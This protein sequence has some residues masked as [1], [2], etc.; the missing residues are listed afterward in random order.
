VTEEKWS[1]P[2]PHDADQRPETDQ[3]LCGD[4]QYALHSAL[5]DLPTLYARLWLALQPG[6]R[7]AP[8]GN[9]GGR[10]KQTHAPLQLDGGADAMMRRCVDI[11]G[12]WM[13][14]VTAAQQLAPAQRRSPRTLRVAT[15]LRLVVKQSDL[16]AL[17]DETERGETVEIE[18]H[19]GVEA[20]DRPIDSA[21]GYLISHSCAV[22]R[23]HLQTLIRLPATPVMRRRQISEL[24]ALTDE[25]LGSLVT[26]VN[27]DEC[28]HLLDLTGVDAAKE[29][30]DLRR[31]IRR[32]LGDTR[33]CRVGVVPCPDEECRGALVMWDGDEHVECVGCRRTWTPADYERLILVTADEAR[34]SGRWEGTK[35]AEQLVTQARAAELAA[36]D[37]A[38][39]RTWVHRNLLTQAGRDGYGRATFRLGD[40]LAVAKS[41]SDEPRGRRRKRT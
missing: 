35:A 32:F 21:T 27:D 18:A 34:A 12:C 33:G 39:V 23:T 29:L 17:P 16:P 24:A 5:G 25:A 3:P 8:P 26:T 15:R 22:L 13:D 7:P 2:G 4:C 37:P 6:M 11:L 31:T 19:Q 36:V 28:L 30:L 1:C 9:Q 40:V 38:T 10:V 20:I 14:V 41:T